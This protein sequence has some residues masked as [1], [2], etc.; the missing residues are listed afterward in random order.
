MGTERKLDLNLLSVIVAL[1]DAGSVSRAALDLGLSQP[2]VSGSLAKLREHFNDPLFVRS[3]RGMAPTPRGAELVSAARD[4]LQ[5]VRE[6]LQPEVVFTPATSSLPF[7][8]ALSDVGETV[9]L[10]KLLKA[11]ADAAPESQVRS[12]SLRPDRLSHALEEG[13]VDLAIGF[14]PDLR[15]SDF[16]QQRLMTHHFVCLLRA[17]HPVQ[18]SRLT[19]GE[20][21]SLEHAV[22]HSS[23]RSQEVFEAYL[24]ARGLTRRVRVFTPHFMSIPRLIVQSDMLVTVPHAVGIQYGTPTH[25]LRVIEP[26]FKSPLIE[27]KQHWHRKMHKDARNVWLRRLVSQL[28][29]EATDEW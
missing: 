15:G 8:F 10:P 21:L 29:N 16:F 17:D 18:G 26:P 2:A 1:M 19:L 27:L 7:T 23:G 28:F 6:R 22:V 13:E 9:F 24:E 11:L 3:T 25:G 14:F 20:F 12:V 5:Q 4:I